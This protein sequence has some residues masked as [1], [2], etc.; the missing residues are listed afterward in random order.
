MTKDTY[1]QLL[2]MRSELGVSRG[3]IQHW[4]RSGVVPVEH[5]V[6]IDRLSE[7]RLNAFCLSQGYSFTHAQSTLAEAVIS[8]FDKDSTIIA[9]I[10]NYLQISQPLLYEYVTEELDPD[11]MTARNMHRGE[12]NDPVC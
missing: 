11:Y 12:D 4:F 1:H 7:G 5:A 10:L 9:E 8:N 2:K 3:A 6:A